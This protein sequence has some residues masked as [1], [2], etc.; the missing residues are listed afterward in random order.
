MKSGCCRGRLNTNLRILKERQQPG[1]KAVK[2]NRGCSL[3][4]PPGSID[5]GRR[6]SDRS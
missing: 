4:G 6:V 3:T 2:L 1:W 5:S